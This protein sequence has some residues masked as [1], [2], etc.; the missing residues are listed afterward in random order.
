MAQSRGRISPPSS[1]FAPRK[2]GLSLRERAVFRFA[3]VPFLNER[4]APFRG[5]KGDYQN[6]TARLSID[7]SIPK[8]KKW[9]SKNMMLTIR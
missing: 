4:H 5:A 9:I 8:A 2:S 1:P 7:A 3:D 6:S